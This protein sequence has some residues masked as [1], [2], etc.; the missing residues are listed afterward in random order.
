MDRNVA[1][2]L[3][4]QG[5]GDGHRSARGVR[6]G[7]LDD[8]H[9]TADLLDGLAHVDGAGEEPDVTDPKTDGLGPPEAQDPRDQD[10]GSI[11]G[12]YCPGQIQNSCSD[13]EHDKA[14]DKDRRQRCQCGDN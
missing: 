9:V 1:S 11:T 14:D 4:Q 5:R 6:L 8:S 12:R 3:V 7:C 2:N 13:S 10:Q